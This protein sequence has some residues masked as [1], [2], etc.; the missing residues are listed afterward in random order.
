MQHL[1]KGSFK[2][3]KFFLLDIYGFLFLF[4]LGVVT[5]FFFFGGV[6]GAS[7]EQDSQH[8]KEITSNQ[9]GVGDVSLNLFFKNQNMKTNF[10]FYFSL[11]WLSLCA[12]LLNIYNFVTWQEM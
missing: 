3:K 5:F 10:T 1:N 8:L 4:F 9:N 12:Q 7:I 11:V 6:I 2:I